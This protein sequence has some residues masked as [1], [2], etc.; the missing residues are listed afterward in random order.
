MDKDQKILGNR[1]WDDVDQDATADAGANNQPWD[2]GTEAYDT[3][4][5]GVNL[6]G[7]AGTID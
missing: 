2:N 4:A 5:Y 6:A 7:A 3:M 1:G